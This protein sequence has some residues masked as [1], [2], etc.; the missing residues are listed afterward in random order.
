MSIPTK[1]TVKKE[2]RPPEYAKIVMSSK[3]QRRREC[4]GADIWVSGSVR[5]QRVV[6][7]GDVSIG[8]NFRIR[9]SWTCK[10]ADGR[11]LD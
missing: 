5:P 4:A 9:K 8:S 1:Y 10:A 6:G 7:G 2:R 11:N 3:W